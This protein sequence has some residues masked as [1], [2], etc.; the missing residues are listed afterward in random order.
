MIRVEGSREKKD[1]ALYGREPKEKNH[2]V[3]KTTG[4]MMVW[5]VETNG[6]S[7]GR[8]TSGDGTDLP[9]PRKEDVRG[10]GRGGVRD[11]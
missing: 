3:T 5:T 11:F 2:G 1:G 9:D 4:S 7:T 6:P 8:P 10:A